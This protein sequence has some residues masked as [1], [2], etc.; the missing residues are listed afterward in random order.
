MRLSIQSL[1][2]AVT[3][4]LTLPAFLDLSQANEK[5]R[6]IKAEKT[7]NGMVKIELR[8]QA[9]SYVINKDAWA[10]FWKVYR[11][12]EK[13]PVVDFASEM[14]VVVVNNDPNGISIRL[15]SN[16]KGDL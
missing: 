3:F 8:N 6:P 10:K 12:E 13:L 16:G 5:P 1:L 15:E 7:W 14:I 4:G 9:P 2:T 11:P